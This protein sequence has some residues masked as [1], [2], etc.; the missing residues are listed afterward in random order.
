MTIVHPQKSSKNESPDVEPHESM[1]IGTRTSS[2]E[3]DRLLMVCASPRDRRELALLAKSENIEMH[4]HRYASDELEALVSAEPTHA[5][6]RDL[7]IEIDEL[8]DFCARQ[9]IGAV[10]STDD[11]PGSALAAIVA[12]HFRLS[13]ANPE[14]NL[15]CQHKYFSRQI[16]QQACPEAVPRFH[17]LDA[18][19]E[20]A[21]PELQF[22]VFVKPVKSYLSMGAQ[23]VDNAADLR[24]IQNDWLRR[25]PFFEIFERLLRQ[26]T[27]RRVDHCFLLAEELLKG[28]QVTL[29]GYAYEGEVFVTGIVDSVMFP[30]T[31]A[32]KRFEYPSSLPDMV[33]ARMRAIARDAILALDYGN[34]QFNIEFTWDPDTY[35]VA[36]IEINPRMSSQFADLYEKVDGTNGYRIMLD[37]ARGLRPRMTRGEGRYTR[38]AS[39]VLRTFENHRVLRIPGPDDIAAVHERYPEVRVEVI[40]EQGKKLSQQLQDGRS[41]RYGLLNIGGRDRQEI[42]EI[43]ESCVQRLGFVLEPA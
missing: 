37:L 25:K 8:F 6:I 29:D 12:R 40:A 22:P 27:G 2:A 16:Q 38:A 30:G 18:R 43:F 4:G 26:Y 36:I 11:Y 42:S 32:F 9:R 15:L 10:A 35:R 19:P 39:C 20:V 5:N 17:L 34:A 23:Q 33:Q 41:Y 24:G 7:R 31:L 3:A 21:L 28:E 1:L 14:A 13:G